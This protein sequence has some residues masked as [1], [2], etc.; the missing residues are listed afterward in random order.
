MNDLLLFCFSFFVHLNIFKGSEQ[1]WIVDLVCKLEETL[2]LYQIEKF[3][4]LRIKKKNSTNKKFENWCKNGCSLS[5]LWLEVE[6]GTTAYAHIS[7]NIPFQQ[8]VIREL[9]SQREH[10]S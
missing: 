1:I 9:M 4:F 5:D 3:L 7:L 2:F 8:S 10:I 6:N